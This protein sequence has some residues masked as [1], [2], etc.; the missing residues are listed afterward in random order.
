MLCH[1]P[2]TLSRSVLARLSPVRIFHL[3]SFAREAP[4]PA[5]LSSQS[6]SHLTTVCHLVFYGARLSDAQCCES[7]SAFVHDRPASPVNM[8]DPIR[9][10]F[11]YGL[12][13]PLWP[14]CS[15][16][17]AGSCMPDP[18]SRIRFS[19]VFLNNAW[20][21]LC[22]TDPDPIWMAWSGFGQTHLV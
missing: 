2:G 11:V 8:S 7:D 14:A 3:D 18:T 17:W 13:W 10:C 1:R 15:Q 21:T 9:K 6:L 4:S 12:L 16:Y 22:K 19:S 20:I 5:P